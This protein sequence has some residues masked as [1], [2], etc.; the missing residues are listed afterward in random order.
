MVYVEGGGARVRGRRPINYM[1]S[2]WV[3]GEKGK[4]FYSLE[5]FTEGRG[6]FL[7]VFVSVC[8]F[9]ARG[10]YIY[11]KRS[12]KRRDLVNDCDNLL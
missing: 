2:F 8:L 9:L 7:E 6:L 12:E 1:K 3:Q 10:K 5:R 4:D 11:V